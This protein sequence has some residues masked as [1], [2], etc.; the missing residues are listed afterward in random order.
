MQPLDRE[1]DGI[2]D[3]RPAPCDPDRGLDEETAHG[4][5]VERERRLQIRMRPEQ[6]QPDAVAASALDEVFE[7]GLDRAEPQGGLAVEGDILHRHAARDVH[8]QEQV[9]ARRRQVDG[10][11]RPL[12]PRRRGDRQRPGDPKQDER[13]TWAGMAVVV[14]ERLDAR[15]GEGRWRQQRRGTQTTH[16]QR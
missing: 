14:G 15:N 1:G 16:Q 8:R 7:D 5:E 2:A 10:V 3:R 4:G 9:P 12:G 6:D 11:A 13:D